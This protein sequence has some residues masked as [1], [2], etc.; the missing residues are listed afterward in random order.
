MSIL[1][2]ASVE[3]IMVIPYVRMTRQSK[4]NKQ[5]KRYLDTQ[6]ALAWEFKKVYH[7]KEPIDEPCIMSYSVHLPHRRRVDDDNIRKALQDALQYA[8]VIKNDYLIKGTDKTRT[9]Q[10]GKSRVVVTLK[11]LEE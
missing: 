11:R 6:Q 5:A 7:N 4:W 10:D 8:G 1:Y 2:Q 9:W 3:G